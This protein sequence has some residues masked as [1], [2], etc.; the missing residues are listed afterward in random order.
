MGLWMR[1]LALVVIECVGTLTV[2]VGVGIR[3]GGLFMV[4]VGVGEVC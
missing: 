2:S 1:F 3:V 4:W